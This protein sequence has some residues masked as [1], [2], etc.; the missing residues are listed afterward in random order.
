[1]QLQH[2]QPRRRR[3]F[4]P[5]AERLRKPIEVHTQRAG[6][7]ARHAS[8]VGHYAQLGLLLLA[9]VGYFYTVRPI[10]QKERLSEQ[11]AQMERELDRVRA[12]VRDA[13]AKIQSLQL[14]AAQA[15]ADA[16]NA[17]ALLE[18]T[19]LRLREARAQ[20]DDAQAKLRTAIEAQQMLGFADS[21]IVA[22][23]LTCEEG[24]ERPAINEAELRN[25][26][27]A[28][29]SN[30]LAPVELSESAKV[31]VRAAV[32]S[33]AKVTGQELAR[34]GVE[35][36]SRGKSES[37]EYQAKLAIAR[38]LDEEY[39]SKNMG[40]DAEP[41]RGWNVK[42]AEMGYRHSQWLMQFDYYNDLTRAIR[43][44]SHDAMRVAGVVGLRERPAAGD[45]TMPRWWGETI[46]ESINEVTRSP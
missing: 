7:L 2:E 10:Y 38:T 46:R 8:T 29:T 20:F 15:R 33:Q 27:A 42:S 11:I 18:T 45:Q 14:S 43:K 5:A 24:V 30:A 44:G 34:I 13:P 1:M 3:G 35:H 4:I 9:A 28:A 21:F 37:E 40:S 22:S 19:E 17:A 16:K 12:E 23:T 25:C 26:W 6:W 31:R 32:E 39:A 41:L 36:R